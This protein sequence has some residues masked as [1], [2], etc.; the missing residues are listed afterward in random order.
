MVN[1][2]AILIT[3]TGKTSHAIT[4]FENHR[5]SLNQHFEWTEVN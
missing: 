2:G 4:V 3:D 5:K 1:L